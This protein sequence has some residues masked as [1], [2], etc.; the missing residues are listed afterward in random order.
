MANTYASLHYHIVFSTKNRMKHINPEIEQRVWAYIGG[1]ARK[2]NM[3]ALQVGG[4]EDHVHVLVM[5][6]P[7]LSPSQIAQFLKGDSSNV[8]G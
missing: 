2:H 8:W 3:A 7:T 4:T 6:Q 5:T 1:V